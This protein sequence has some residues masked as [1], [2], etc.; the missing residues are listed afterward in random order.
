MIIAK[1]YRVLQKFTIKKILEKNKWLQNIAVSGNRIRDIS[2]FNN[3]RTNIEVS[4]LN[5]RGCYYASF[6]VDLCKTGH[7]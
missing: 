7:Q 3:D 4:K 6:E 5:D 1:K 2:V